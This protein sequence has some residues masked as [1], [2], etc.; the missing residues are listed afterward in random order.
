MKRIDTG[1]GGGVD[2][3]YQVVGRGVRLADGSELDIGTK[4]APEEVSFSEAQV[5]ELLRMRQ[6]EKVEG[7]ITKPLAAKVVKKDGDGN[8]NSAAC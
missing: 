6:I 8:G 1:G 3:R 5:C 2:E 7:L 4:F